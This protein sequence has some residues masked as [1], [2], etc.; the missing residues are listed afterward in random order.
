MRS[1][2]ECICPSRSQNVTGRRSFYSCRLRT[3]AGFASCRVSGLIPR[4]SF[5][6][7]GEHR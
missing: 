5:L 7:T 4:S 1:S 6:Y 3:R 2:D